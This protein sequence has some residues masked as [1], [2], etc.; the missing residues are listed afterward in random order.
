MAARA[1]SNRHA[2]TQGE[3]RATAR[4]A[5]RAAVR[6]VRRSDG[7]RKLKL[8]LP[9]LS[10]L[11][12]SD[13]PARMAISAEIAERFVTERVR[14]ALSD[15]YGHASAE[16]NIR[17]AEQALEQAQGAL[18]GALRAFE[19]FDE[20]AARQRL[21]EL[22]EARDTAQARVDQLGRARPAITL[23]GAEDW[24]RLT[25]SER[26]GLIRATVDRATVGPGRGASR[27][28]VELFS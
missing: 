20:P 5:S 26:R 23:N 15:A 13:C 24:E 2:R 7:C 28:A 12:T 1:A 6:D 22:R 18:D 9:G 25:L 10:L 21:V 16:T 4:A 8:G 14:E 19:G 27:L 17:Q 3:V 11:P